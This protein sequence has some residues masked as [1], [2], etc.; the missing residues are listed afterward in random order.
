DHLVKGSASVEYM[1]RRDVTRKLTLAGNYG[2]EQLGQGSGS[3]SQTG[4]LNSLFAYRSGD[5]QTLIR[6]LSLD[7]EHEF[8]SVFTGFFRVDSKRL[9]GNEMVPLLARDRSPVR[10]VSLNQVSLA[11]RFAWEERIDRGHFKKAHLFTRY[12]VIGISLS[13]GLRGVTSDDF[14]F[15]RGDFTFDW[16]IPA[17]AFGFGTIHVDA[18]AILGEVPYPFLKLHEGNPTWFLDKTAFSCMDYYEFASDRWVSTM[19]EHNLNGLILGRI[20]LIRR[21]DLREIITLKAAV[22]TL[23]ETN[24]NGRILPVEGLSSIEKPYVEAGAGLS[25]LFRVIRV[26]AHWRLTHRRPDGNNFRVTVGFDVQF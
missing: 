6:S 25:N 8:S 13:G 23:S 4:F 1:L 21:L 9:F 2:Y 17:G 18:G 19:Y 26:D 10:T 5:K 16:R 20:P 15:L 3:I 14:S 12:P 22:G 7:Y 24:L 11:A